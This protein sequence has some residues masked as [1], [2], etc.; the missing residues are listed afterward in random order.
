MAQN[1]QNTEG[2]SFLFRIRI[3]RIFKDLTGLYDDV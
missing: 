1:G 3:G 2:A